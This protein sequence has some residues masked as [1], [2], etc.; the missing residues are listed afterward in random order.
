MPWLEAELEKSLYKTP[1]Q[2]ALG[3]QNNAGYSPG[4]HSPHAHEIRRHHRNIQRPCLHL[5]QTMN[6]VCCTRLTATQCAKSMKTTKQISIPASVLCTHKLSSLQTYPIISR[7]TSILTQHSKHCLGLGDI[8]SN[9]MALKEVIYNLFNEMVRIWGHKLGILCRLA[10]SHLQY[11]GLPPAW[12]SNKGRI[13]WSTRYSPQAE[14]QLRRS[15]A[16]CGCVGRWHAAAEWLFWELLRLPQIQQQ[17]W[18]PWMIC[19]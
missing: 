18:R 16:S 14:L 1:H 10:E 19:K 8:S 9:L 5:M 11:Q 3:Y 4:N 2:T 13:S 7:R 17:Q 12:R 6:T 15:S